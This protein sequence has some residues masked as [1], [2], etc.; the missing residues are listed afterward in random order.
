MAVATARIPELSPLTSGLP[1]NMADQLPIYIASENKTK[2]VTLEDLNTFFS[3]G[4]GGTS[5]PPVVH[6][7]EMIVII[8]EELNESDTVSIPSLAGLDFSLERGGMPLIPLK[9]DESN[10]DEAEFE[11]LDAGGFKLLNGG[12]VY[13]GERFK[14]TIYSLIGGSYPG[15]VT[16]SGGGFIKGIKL[17]STN[18]TLDPI[19]D[20]NKLIQ[21]RGSSSSLVVTLPSVDDIDENAFVAVELNISNTKPSQVATSGGQFIYLNNVSK[22]SIYLHPGEVVWLYKT[23][24]GWYVINDF[25]KC[26]RGIASPYAAYDAE[27]GELICNGQTVNRA[28]YPRLWEKVQSLSNSLVSE[29]TWQTAAVYRQGNTYTTTQP[30]SGT[31]ET[32]PFPYR[33]CFSTG[34]GTTTFRLPDLRNMALRGVKVESGTDNERYQNSVRGIY[35]KHQFESHTHQVDLRGKSTGDNAFTKNDGLGAT[36][37][38]T[39]TA[40]GGAETRMDNIGVLWVIKY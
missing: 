40:A 18:T 30:G 29:S 1:L 12:Q 36:A 37:L 15:G 32:I 20:I 25:W 23:S 22:T 19:N 7:G 8:S 38:Y 3:L 11:I 5:H 27:L 14:L 16:S 33:G 21:V 9:E 26:Y 13:T 31:Y 39:T 10:A 24:D 35:Q 4:G 2:R 34:N 28:D 6:G 17:V